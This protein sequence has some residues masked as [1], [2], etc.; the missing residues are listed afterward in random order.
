MKTYLSRLHVGDQKAPV[1]MV[2]EDG[3]ENDNDGV[4][5]GH[6][7]PHLR[8]R[9]VL[10]RLSSGSLETVEGHDCRYSMEAR[11]DAKSSFMRAVVEELGLCCALSLSSFIS[12]KSESTFSVAV[13]IHRDFPPKYKVSMLCRP[14]SFYGKDKSLEIT[15][16]CL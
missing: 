11:L 9:A 3:R 7:V 2:W 14:R 6:L 5:K 10:E 16:A 8:Q 4:D 12:G 15:D 13:R 1:G